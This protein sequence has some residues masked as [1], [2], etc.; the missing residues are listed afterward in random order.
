MSRAFYQYKFLLVIIGHWLLITFAPFSNY[1]V[2]FSFTTQAIHG[3]RE[4]ERLQWGDMSES[5][6]RRVRAVAFPEGSPLLGPIHVLDLDKE[7]Y[8][9]PHIDSVKVCLSYLYNIDVLHTYHCHL[10]IINVLCVCSLL[11][12]LWKHYCRTEPVVRQCYAI[13][14][15]KP[16]HRLGGLASESA[17][18]LYIKVYTRLFYFIFDISQNWLEKNIYHKM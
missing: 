11:S 15:R 10:Y 12:V 4:T 6:L 17:L 14:P 16:I 5:I 9:K 8:I 13:G 7:G 1:L 3:Y 2:N 18:T